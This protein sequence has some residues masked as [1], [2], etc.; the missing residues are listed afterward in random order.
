ME[1]KEIKLLNKAY[2]ELYNL[3]SYYKYKY[4]YMLNELEEQV[5]NKGYEFKLNDKTQKFR[6][7]KVKQ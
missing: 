4:D 7:I 1:K 2:D 6:L 3:N 5:K